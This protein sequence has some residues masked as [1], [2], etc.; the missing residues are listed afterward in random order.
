M[1]MSIVNPS[2]CLC[3]NKDLTYLGRSINLLNKLG[4]RQLPWRTPLFATIQ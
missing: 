2:A 1:F 4:E 3:L